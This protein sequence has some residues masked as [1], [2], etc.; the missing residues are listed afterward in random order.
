MH[1]PPDEE[2]YERRPGAKRVPI[3]S[4][5]LKNVRDPLDLEYCPECGRAMDPECFQK[6]FHGQEGWQVHL[7]WPKGKPKG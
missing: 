5:C 7:R 6:H 2:S 1:C 3:C 4:V